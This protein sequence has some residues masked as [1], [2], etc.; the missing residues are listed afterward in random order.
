MNGFG[1]FNT[2]IVPM[3]PTTSAINVPSADSAY[4]MFFRLND[5]APGASDEVTWYYAAGPAS[6]AS[7][8]LSDLSNGANPS[9]PPTIISPTN[10]TSLNATGVTLTGTG[11]AGANIEI[12]DGS[13]S[14][15]A[16]V[17]VDGSGNYSYTTNTLPPGAYTFVARQTVSPYGESSP[18]SVTLTLDTTAPAVPTITSPMS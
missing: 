13:G 7:S 9:P 10:G 14:L 5:L 2:R 4:G 11:T 16:N 3:N 8:I 18:V 17:I 1:P 15:L 6:L 12:V